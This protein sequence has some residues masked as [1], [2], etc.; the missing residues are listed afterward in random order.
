MELP[1]RSQGR[2]ICREG[3]LNKSLATLLIQ[4]LVVTILLVGCASVWPAASPQ[5]QAIGEFRAALTLPQLPLR[6]VETGEMENRRGGRLEVAIYEDSAGRKFSVDTATNRVVEM[7][8]R[9][10]LPRHGSTPSGAPTQS[11]DALRAAARRIII[12]TI[13]AF[14]SLESGWPYEEGVKGDNYF[15]TWSAEMV[16]GAMQRPFA[17]IG[18]HTSGLVF[19]YYNTLMP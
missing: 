6:L 19:A 18:I 5:V 16:P 3:N 15:F 2:D 10:L 14:A 8:A 4:S 17:Q 7:D 12:T 11:P 9:A 13:P 1:T